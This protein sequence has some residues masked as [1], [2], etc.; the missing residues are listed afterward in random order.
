MS[1]QPTTPQGEETKPMI[2]GAI[3]NRNQ[4]PESDLLPNQP[5]PARDMKGLLRFAM[6][7]TAMEDAPRS[8][9]L[10]PMD[11]E[12]KKFLEEALKAMT[13]DLV[14]VL[15]KALDKLKTVSDLKPEDDPEDYEE[16]L[17]T[18]SD[19]VDNIDL[20]N[21]FHKIGGFDVLIPC[22]TTCHTSLQWRTAELIAELTQN[23]PYCQSR[24]L[25]AGLLPTLLEMVDG[26]ANEAVRVKALYAISC[27]VRDNAD[28]L[29]KFSEDDGFSVL[30]RAMQSDVDKLKV[31]SAFLLS[32]LCSQHPAIRDD[33]QKMG[34]VHQLVG[35]IN[36]ERTPGHEHLLSALLALV[37][38]HKKCIED[39]RDP[40]LQLRSTLTSY[41]ELVKGK[42]ECQEEVDY[43]QQILSTVFSEDSNCGER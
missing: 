3:E 35:L 30:L 5:R 28:G 41:I 11:E 15:I 23:N 27:L 24:I 42:E 2:M 12:K 22:L 25:S 14:Q 31:K 6:E 29:K 13:V 26:G 7:A 36:Q 9:N 18:I 21:D 33:L 10:E 1:G 4:T 16:A 32:S 34:W 43:A 39:C 38:D 17:E 19:T 40:K 20:A 37:R 8:S